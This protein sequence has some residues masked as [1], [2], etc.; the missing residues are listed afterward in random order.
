MTETPK[1]TKRPVGRKADPATAILA[2]VKAARKAVAYDRMPLAGGLVPVKGREHHLREARRWEGVED[3]RRLTDMPG[4]DSTLIPAL[5]GALAEQDM[6]H[7]RDGLVRLAALAVAAVE[8][9]DREA[10]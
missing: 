8:D 4:W 6:Q 2:E 10:G 1:M 9:I 3:A 7:A 5:Y